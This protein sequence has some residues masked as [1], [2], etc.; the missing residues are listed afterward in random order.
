MFRLSPAFLAA[1]LVAVCPACAGSPPVVDLGAGSYFNGLPDGAARPGS[2]SVLSMPPRVSP[3][4]SGPP[5]TNEFWSSWIYEW[6]Q[7]NR[8][9]SLIHPHPLMVK[10]INRGLA[11]NYNPTPTVEAR[12]Y[13]HS[14][15]IATTLL[16][17]VEG[18]DAPEVRTESYGD[19]HVRGEWPDAEQTMLA[20]IGH[21]LPVVTLESDESNTAFVEF[22]GPFEIFADLGDA[23]G[24]RVGSI[25]YGLFAPGDWALDGDGPG[26]TATA[27]LAGRGCF[28]IAALPDD[29]PETLSM[30][31]DH[32][33]AIVTDTRVEWEYDADAGEVVVTHTVSSES[34][35]GSGRHPLIG[36]YRHQWLHSDQATVASYSTAR[37]EMKLAVADSFVCR[38]PFRGVL[39]ALPD[40][41]AFEPGQLAALVDE[42]ETLGLGLSAD[43][44]WSGKAMQR[45]AQLASVADQVPDDAARERFLGFVRGELEDWLNARTGDRFFAYDPEWNTFLGNPGSFNLAREMNDHHFHYGYHIFAAAIL[46]MHDP[47]WAENYAGMVELQI[48]DVANWDRGDTRFPFLRNFDPYAGHAWA[49]G[50]QGFDAGNNQ[51]S[52]SESMN[53]ATALILWGSVMGREDIRDLGIYLHATEAVAI[54]QYWFDVDGEVF[55]EGLSKPLAGIVWSDGIDYTTWFSNRLEHIHGIN[56]LPV[57]GGSLYLGRRPGSMAANWDLLTTLNGGPPDTWS[58]VLWSALATEDPALALQQLEANP[59]EPVEEGDSRARTEHWIR[60]L[61]ETGPV[62]PEIWADSPTA[63]VFSDGQTRTYAAWNPGQVPQTVRFSDGFGMLVAPGANTVARRGVCRV[64][65]A[66]PFGELGD[67]DFLAFVNAFSAGL[68]PA[69][70]DGNDA[71]DLADL[72]AFVVGFIQGCDP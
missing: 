64:D 34:A 37:G 53:F 72:V 42:A 33:F 47:E 19:W 55:P 52:S 43:T 13:R 3:G 62:E 65:F 10:A 35:D 28:A 71:Y 15:T 68:P 59:A 54:E 17:G 38:F 36:L 58:G 51:E 50:H 7:G 48:R 63:T 12:R 46:A 57:S 29:S 30:F 23:L 6:S 41:G 45:S 9:G 40:A 2:S 18:L 4:F 69:D 26:A 22:F 60:T 67:P 5:A 16:A 27:P 25:A 31:R 14:L 8:M 32:A 24:V 11:I 1:L 70:L 21:G 49:S 44:Y 20:T 56:F 66:P 39:P 61:A